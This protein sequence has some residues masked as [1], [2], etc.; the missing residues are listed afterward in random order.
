MVLKKQTV[1]LLTMLSLIIVLSV[2]YMTSP[3]Q[4]PDSMAYLGEEEM[5]LEEAGETI[6]NIEE[7][8]MALEDEDMETGV[9]SSISSDE[10]FTTIRLERDASRS[11]MLEDYTNVIASDVPAEV[12]AAAL[13]NRDNLLALEQKETMLETLIRAKGY[14]DVLVMTQE[15]QVKII[16]KADTLSREEAVEIL[17]S[18][19]EQLGEKN[20]AVEH[21]IG[22]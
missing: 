21:Q 22:K 9:I 16:V 14:E 13:A 5:N 17:A 3:A 6:I 15:D 1:W 8:E 10:L 12:S 11:R 19:R 20:I 18:A 2:Y 4:T 7:A